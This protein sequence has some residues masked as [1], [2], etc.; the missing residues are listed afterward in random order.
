[1]KPGP[2]QIPLIF[3]LTLTACGHTPTTTPPATPTPT[4]TPAPATLADL[5]ADVI[6]G[7]AGQTLNCRDDVHARVSLTNNAASPVLVT[8]VFR[9]SSIL[10]GNCNS[11]PDFTFQI[12]RIVGPNTTAAV[13]DR[14]IYSS[15]SGC[16]SGRCSGGTCEV[17]QTFQVVT[18]LGAVPAGRFSYKVEFFDCLGCGASTSAGPPRQ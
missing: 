12:N 5:S 14:P 8:G 4:P 2:W 7:E 15:G 18:E 1:M 10:H 16:C 3:A 6:S 11:A 17:L 9:G 13:M